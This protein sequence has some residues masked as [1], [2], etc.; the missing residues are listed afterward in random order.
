MIAEIIG[1]GA[2]LAEDGALAANTRLLE[3]ELGTCGIEVGASAAVGTS[4]QSLRAAIARAL[5]RSD[6]VIL[7]GGLGPGP[8]GIAKETVCEGALPPPR[9]ARTE[10]QADEGGL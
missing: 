2:A 10:P 5:G 8:D 3:K 1:V 7:M 6:V 4:V 9:H